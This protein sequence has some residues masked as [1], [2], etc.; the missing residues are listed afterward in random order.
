MTHARSRAHRVAALSAALACAQPSCSLASAIDVCSR[1]AAPPEQINV[2]TEG[3]QLVT[4]NGALAT[5][6]DGRALVAWVSQ[7][8]ATDPTEEVRLLRLDGSGRGV[9][10]CE[11][12]REH[13]VW[14]ATADEPA[15]TSIVALTAHA[16]A[17]LADAG[18]LAWGEGP[19]GS[20]GHAPAVFA[21][22]IDGRSGCVFA[23]ARRHEL[24]LG[25]PEAVLVDLE[26]VGT[27][28]DEFLVVWSLAPREGLGVESRA[29]AFRIELGEPRWLPVV[30]DTGTPVA[31]EPARVRFG[32]RA[33]S[34]LAAV[35]AGGSVVL[36]TLDA[37]TLEPSLTLTDGALRARARPI[38]IGPPST[39]TSASGVDVDVAYDGAQLLAVWTH[40]GDAGRQVMGRLLT[41][42]GDFLRSEL[43]PQGDA[44]VVPADEEAETIFPS[45][46][47]LPGGGFVVTWV[48]ELPG[49][50]DQQNRSVALGVVTAEGERGFTNGACDRSE[51]DLVGIL[52]GTHS[53]PSVTTLPDGSAVV[54][55]NAVD[56]GGADASGT[57]VYALGASTRQ[58]LPRP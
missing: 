45:V 10:T 36:V 49:A 53:R 21:L 27:G 8:S 20:A 34:S 55:W 12:E 35:A 4:S 16:P 19:E 33:A 48:R 54:A 46:A 23:G 43:S 2:R 44:F 14:P 32:E 50:G 7:R 25:P 28:A 40:V 31:D 29:R 51:I 57:S 47:A 5:M 30:D 1:E 26:I 41:P 3:D 56:A 38:S 9:I 6:P 58:L 22:P 37:L 39:Q 15:S 52:P 42:Q 24:G 17:G 18:L 11:N 13:T